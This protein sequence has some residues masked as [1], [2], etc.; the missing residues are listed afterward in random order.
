MGWGISI[1]LHIAAVVVF[2]VV[3]NRAPPQ[4]DLDQAIIKTK[5]VKLGKKR[6]EK[7]LPRIDA[8]KAPP[9]P[10]K[11]AAIANAPADKKSPKV[12]DRDSAMKEALSKVKSPEPDPDSLTDLINKR[13]GTPSDEG[14]EQGSKFGDA[15]T[16]RLKAQYSDLLAAKIQNGY[17]VPSTLSDQERI[18]LRA[19]LL[20]Q[21]GSE[22]ELIT[23]KVV[24]SSG[25]ATYDNAV[26]RSAKQSA[27]FQPPPLTLRDFF[28][29]GVQIEFCPTRCS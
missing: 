7:L 18:S 25:N 29:K 2:V 19:V 21:I 22:G 4:M 9:P 15:I 1:A 13:L 28:A 8:K 17:E 11:A 27:P 24:K 10:P 3:A 5:L 14:H 12:T 26:L 6:D 16:G 20:V 23:A